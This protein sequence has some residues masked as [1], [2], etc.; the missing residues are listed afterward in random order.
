V[1]IV[2]NEAN[3]PETATLLVRSYSPCD[4]DDEFSLL[5]VLYK[6]VPLAVISDGTTNNGEIMHILKFC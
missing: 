1:T 2:K 6:Q 3:Y 5:D 4:F